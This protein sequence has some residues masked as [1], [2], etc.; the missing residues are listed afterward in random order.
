[1]L[2]AWL[3][4]ALLALA[5]LVAAERH[6]RAL[7]YQPN[8]L[9]S[10]QLWSLERGRLY[11]GD[12]IPLAILGASR[13]E[14]GTD[15]AL[16]RERLPKYEPVMLAINGR[17]PLAVLRDL[18]EDE[19]FH[20]AVLCDVDARGLSKQ[21]REMQ[22]GYASYFHNQ[23]TPSWRIHR[24]ALTRWQQWL[25]IANPDFSVAALGKHLFAG[26]EAFRPYHRF[27]ADRTGDIDF[28]QVDV[29]AVTQHFAQVLREGT[30]T[31]APVTPEQWLRELDQ[32]NEWVRRIQARG[33]TV[34][35]YE[36]PTLADAHEIDE[37]AF[38]RQLYWDRFA[39]TTPARMLNSADVPRL[40]SARL[41]D[42]VHVD[43]RDKP[44]LT[45]ALVAALLERGMLER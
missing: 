41:P 29:S 2:Q 1:M 28:T 22:A 11:G 37:R 39:A 25:V 44:N 3:I 12:R 15:L 20:G 6:W 18:A 19:A 9:D 34:I 40:A 30:I 8:I 43:F 45:E 33:G 32:V 36:T 13:I 23:W 16:M 35:F 5:A 21:H 42:Q 31:K 7:G 10:A 26:G 38:P 17:F 24:E 14:F 27:H 4:A